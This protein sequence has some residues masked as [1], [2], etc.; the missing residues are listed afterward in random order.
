[1][2]KK[3]LC[4]WQ[5]KGDKIRFG[6]GNNWKK[7]IDS[8]WLRNKMAMEQSSESLYKFWPKEK[9]ENKTFL[10][11]GCGSGIFSLAAIEAGCSKV[12]SFDYDENSV[13]CTL[14]LKEKYNNNSAWHIE[15]G[16]ILDK[17]YIKS[18]GKFDFVYA[19]GVLHHTGDMWN[20]IRNACSLVKKEGYVFIAIYNNYKGKGSSEYWLKIK[21]KYNESGA[22]IRGIIIIE[23]ILRDFLRNFI[24]SLEKRIN[25]LRSWMSK[26]KQRKG[27]SYYY[28]VID[29]VG[30]YPYEYATFEELSF[31]LNDLGFKLEDSTANYGTGNHQLILNKIQDSKY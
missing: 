12:F 30:G 11:I 10:D 14:K 21:K 19:W 5:I 31:F 15:R 8:Y 4:N 1:M 16:D 23:Y 27:M 9:L 24:E 6:F 13:R 17:E 7:F 2:N 20:A 22:L 18:I 26:T 3:H 29:W 28:N 25:P